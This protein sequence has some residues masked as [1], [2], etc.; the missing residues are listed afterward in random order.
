MVGKRRNLKRKKSRK[1]CILRKIVEDSGIGWLE[2][3][4]KCWILNGA[5]CNGK[6]YL[7]YFGYEYPKEW[8]FQLPPFKIGCEIPMGTKFKVEIIDTW[9]MTIT[10]VEELYEVTDKDRYNYTC[11][12]NP[13]V[14]LPGREFTA[15][16]IRKVD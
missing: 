3:L 16:R 12:Y 1:D 6:Y 8:K 13:K 5:G 11:N 10:P 14:E 7:Y 4:D 15:I 9:N 2:L